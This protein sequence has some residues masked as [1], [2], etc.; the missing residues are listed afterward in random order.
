LAQELE[1]SLELGDRL[2]TEF[3]RQVLLLGEANEIEQKRLQIQFDY[4]DR[5]K[6]IAELKN[7]EQQTNLSQLNDEIRR[8][9]IIEL[10]TEALKK[11]AEEAE[12]LFKKSLSE[13]EFG[14]SGGGSIADMAAEMQQS[15]SDFI[16]PANQVK[17]AAEAIGVA[18]S[19]SF[20]DIV[21]GSKSAQEAIADFFNRIANALLDYVA[22]AI[23]QYIALGIARAF[24]GG[25]PLSAAG[26]SLTGTGALAAPIPGLAIGARAMGGPVSAGSPYM[27]GE[28]GPELFVPGRSGTIVP[29]DEL[30]GGGQTNVVVNVDARGSSVEGNAPDGKRLGAAISAAVQQELIKQKRPGGLLAV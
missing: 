5:A 11:Q 26:S 30:G 4:E 20:K 1:R 27:V 10:Q 22:L 16:S 19:T 23:A 3:S 24:A 8:L 12:K 18:F 9:E 21:S 13:V 2:G 7:T 25:D 17:T 15:F 14:V 29:N 6:Q 28:R